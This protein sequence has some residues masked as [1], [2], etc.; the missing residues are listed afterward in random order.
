MP[1]KKGISGNPG[2][3][4]KRTEQVIEIEALARKYA[5]QAMQ[6]LVKIATSG[7]SDTARVA[8]ATEILDRAYGRPRQTLHAHGEHSNVHY[9]I[10]DK[11]LSEEEWER[12]HCTGN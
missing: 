9:M 3:R 7:K 12:K 6:A 11:P 5:P 8:A 1:F 4:P 10:S 2:G